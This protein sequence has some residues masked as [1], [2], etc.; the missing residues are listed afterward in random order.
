M[1]LKKAK[2]VL[3]LN[4]KDFY[5]ASFNECFVF[6]VTNETKF[7]VYIQFFHFELPLFYDFIRKCVKFLTYLDTI[8]DNKHKIKESFYIN[9]FYKT[10]EEKLTNND[11]LRT[12]EV[13]VEKSEN[14]QTFCIDLDFFDSL[15]KAIPHV[16]FC[17]FKL[18]NSQKFF[19]YY[20]CEKEEKNLLE[21][22]NNLKR[23]LHLIKDFE[24]NIVVHDTFDLYQIFQY[25]FKE[26]HIIN[27]IRL[28][29]S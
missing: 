24:K 19:I 11:N 10:K 13:Y 21:A 12:I 8:T 25:Y 2:L 16:F 27:Q 22:K 7:V 9:Y 20:C 29:L 4:K 3:H 5:L 17:S 14:L 6:G 23:F 28:L 18:S 15:L 1:E 26:I